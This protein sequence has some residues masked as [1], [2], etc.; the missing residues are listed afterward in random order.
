M[1]TYA[2][3]SIKGIKFSN[4]LRKVVVKKFSEDVDS[5]SVISE[6]EM[7]K[8]AGKL[9]FAPSIFRWSVK[10]RWYEEE[11]INGFRDYS[12]TNSLDSATVLK[13]YY[14]YVAPC[15]E[16][17]FQFQ[18]PILINA[19]D[20]VKKVISIIEAKSLS[21]QGFETG[22][23]DKINKFISTTTERLVNDVYPVYLVFTHGDFNPSN[24][25]NIKKWY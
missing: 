8:K 9:E 13:K 11:Y 20:Y 6:I 1:A 5:E 21:R 3:L 15:I 24:I 10:E 18:S 23:S 16:S 22:I 19:N 2:C 14:T 12:V 4:L 7:V 25:I 17:M